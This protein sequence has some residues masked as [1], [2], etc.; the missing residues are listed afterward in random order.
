MITRNCAN[1]GS[2]NVFYAH[3]NPVVSFRNEET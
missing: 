1:R 2:L 3:G